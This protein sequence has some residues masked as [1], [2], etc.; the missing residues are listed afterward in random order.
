MW[1]SIGPDAGLRRQTKRDASTQDDDSDGIP[2]PEPQATQ[3]P[4]DPNSIAVPEP[5][6][7][8]LGE[9]HGISLVEDREY[10]FA[11][12]ERLAASKGMDAPG[13]FYAALEADIAADK[14]RAENDPNNVDVGTPEPNAAIEAKTRVLAVVESV[15]REL[16]QMED[17]FLAEFEQLAWTPL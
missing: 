2:G 8:L 13:D 7:E 11:Q 3:K 4:P 9:I 12:L 6:G 10:M 5:K 14:R 1:F 17:S 16:E 15:A